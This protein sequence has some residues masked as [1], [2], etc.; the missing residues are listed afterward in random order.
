MKFSS[1][2]FLA[3]AFCC[4]IGA[5]SMFATPLVDVIACGS[6]SASAGTSTLPTGTGPSGFVTCPGE[7]SAIIPAG[8]TFI[9]MQLILQSDYSSGAGSANQTQT[10]FSSG[11]LAITTDILTAGTTNPIPGG[12]SS[13]W[14]DSLGDAGGAGIGEPSSYFLDGPGYLTTSMPFAGGTVAYS[15]V[16]EAG[17]AIQTV[18]G[19]VYELISYGTQAPEPT[20][21]VL[22]GAGLGL[23]GL[24]R[25][26]KSARQ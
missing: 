1:K 19:N 10:T 12:P 18:S 15:D 24:L 23:L 21:F 4:L 2:L 25:R 6:F 11:T 3:V 5:S 16:V 20:T 17:S 26:R 13:A 22:M 9:G 14:S 7:T 8:D